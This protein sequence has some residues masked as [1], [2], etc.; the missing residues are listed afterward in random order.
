MINSDTPRQMGIWEVEC[1]NC[2]LWKSC[3]GGKTAP[4]GCKWTGKS[5]YDCMNC[6]LICR[7]RYVDSKDGYKDSFSAQF[8]STKSLEELEIKQDF[9]TI[10]SFP[11]F[12]PTQTRQLPVN[13]KLDWAGVI[14]EDL[15]T[16]RKKPPLDPKKYL[17]TLKSREHLRVNDN[18]NLIAVMNGNDKILEYFWASNRDKFYET[19]KMN[20]FLAVTGP[21]FSVYGNDLDSHSVLMLR[22]QF[23]VLQELYDR[24]INFIPNI[25]FRNDNERDRDE[26][27]NWLSENKSIHVVSRDFSSTKQPGINYKTGM[28]YLIEILNKVGRRL[29]VLLNG[30]GHAKAIEAIKLLMNAGCTCSILTSDPIFL[31]RNGK[32]LLSRNAIDLYTEKQMYPSQETLALNN[33][34]FFTDVLNQF[35]PN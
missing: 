23:T 25:Y 31:G 15:V 22:R 4:C 20:D 11:L 9:A 29:H 32:V 5:R 14:L 3:G 28:K 6:N 19:L 7:E 2:Q 1:P 24:N 8:F 18:G 12:I 27:I 35:A 16:N 13:T 21:T 33:V 34:R 30:I 26:W 10:K 17:V